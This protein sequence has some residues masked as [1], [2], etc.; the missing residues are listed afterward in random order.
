MGEKGKASK[1]ALAIWGPQSNRDLA[2]HVQKG[3]WYEFLYSDWSGRIHSGRVPSPVGLEIIQAVLSFCLGLRC[4]KRHCHGLVLPHHWCTA[5][6]A[7]GFYLPFCHLLF[8]ELGVEEK[9]V[10]LLMSPRRSPKFWSTVSTA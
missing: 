10:P 3:F 5:E 1:L 4:N 9:S 2:Y 7:G 8:E 6:P